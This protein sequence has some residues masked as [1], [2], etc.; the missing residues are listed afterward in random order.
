MGELPF[1]NI[2]FDSG[3]LVSEKIDESLSGSNDCFP[4]ADKFSLLRIWDETSLRRNLPAD[5]ELGVFL[6]TCRFRKLPQ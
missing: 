4:D 5:I 2:G 6:H 1:R 3:V